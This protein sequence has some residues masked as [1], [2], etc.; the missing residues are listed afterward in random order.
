MLVLVDYLVFKLEKDVDVMKNLNKIVLGLLFVIIGVVVLLNS[1]EVT[2]INFFFK[3]WWTLFIIVPSLIGI[4]N[5]EDKTGNI[6]GLVIGVSLLLMVRDVLSFD[7]LV[8]LLLP[9]VLIIIGLNIIF[10]ETITRKISEKVSE[11]NENLE[12]ITATFGEQK[13]KVEKKFLGSNI[14]SVFGNVSLD[15]REATFDNETVIKASAIF[16]GITI[17]LPKGVSVQI[18]S[19]PIFGSV[20]NNYSR[21]KNSDKVIY[22][23][24]FALFGGVNI[25]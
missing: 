18:K 8:K 12:Q 3:G 25:K 5:D 11:K 6:I 9:L 22:I 2:N 4:F 13:I 1:L 17:R 21:D 19:T 10:K 7:L 24:A 16:G 20:N 14:D 23:E 15:L